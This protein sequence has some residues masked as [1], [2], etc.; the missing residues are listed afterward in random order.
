MACCFAVFHP[1]WTLLCWIL[2]KTPEASMLIPS[3]SRRCYLAPSDQYLNSYVVSKCSSRWT[4]TKVSFCTAALP[5]LGSTPT[6][7]NLSTFTV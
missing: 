7:I 2:T 6:T 4:T 1:L 5:C 3:R